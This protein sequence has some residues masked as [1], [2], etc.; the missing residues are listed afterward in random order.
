MIVGA[1]YDKA[2]NW[3]QSPVMLLSA[4]SH[5]LKQIPLAKYVSSQLDTSQDRSVAISAADCR[6][7]PSLEGGT[8]K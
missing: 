2:H 3:P 6:C 8:F 1:A 7:Y 4:A 5:L